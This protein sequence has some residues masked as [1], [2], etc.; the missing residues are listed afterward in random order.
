MLWWIPLWDNMLR[1]LMHILIYPSLYLI[2]RHAV[3]DKMMAVDKT[4]MEVKISHHGVPAADNTRFYTSSV[5]FV[6]L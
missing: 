4:E 6:H 1:V 5:I 2:A 3:R